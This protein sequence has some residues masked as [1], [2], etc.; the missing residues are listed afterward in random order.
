MAVVAVD[1]PDLES[2]LGTA[3]IVRCMCSTVLSI[4]NGLFSA[5]IGL[6]VCV[7]LLQGEGC[8][9]RCAQG[10]ACQDGREVRGARGDDGAHG[11]ADDRGMGKGQLRPHHGGLLVLLGVNPSAAA[12]D[13]GTCG[14]STA[15]WAWAGTR[16]TF[17]HVLCK[18]L[19]VH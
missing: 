15:T 5:M 19:C 11:A 12:S 18:H 8:R 2:E 3:A 7:S 9:D 6:L 17:V 1:I 14:P 16:L 4:W 10:D 13:G